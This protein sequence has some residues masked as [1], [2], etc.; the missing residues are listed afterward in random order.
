MTENSSP[1]TPS[2]GGEPDEART[3]GRRIVI[4]VGAI[5]TI[6]GTVGSLAFGAITAYLDYQVSIDQLQQSEDEEQERIRDQASKVAVW[7]ENLSE[8]RQL[9][10]YVM[11]RSL[12]PIHNLRIKLE[13]AYFT[14][15]PVTWATFTYDAGTIPPCTTLVIPADGFLHAK[16]DRKPIKLAMMNPMWFYFFDGQYRMWMNTGSKLISD[17]DTIY[18]EEDRQQGDPEDE[19]GQLL[20]NKLSKDAPADCM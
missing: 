9:K 7:S 17:R 14:K 4:W 1:Q 3:R 16:K 13:S 12:A 10:L 5:V 18:A 2:T 8:G 15:G 19:R 20:L 11:N 6:L